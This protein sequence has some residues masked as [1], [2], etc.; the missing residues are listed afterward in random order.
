MWQRLQAYPLQLA[1][2]ALHVFVV[3]Q[4]KPNYPIEMLETWLSAAE[5]ERA[6]AYLTKVL[7][8]RY[9][10]RHGMLREILSVY[11][12]CKPAQLEFVTGLNG[13]PRLIAK[14]IHF[15][16]SHS[17]EYVLIGVCKTPIGIDI[18][19][20][21]DVNDLPLIAEYHFAQE[22]QDALFALPQREQLDGFYR[23]WTRKEAFIKMDG[24]GL[25]IALDS[26]IVSIG[27]YAEVIKSNDVDV[28]TWQIKNVPVPY[29]YAGAVVMGRHIKNLAIIST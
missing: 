25:G 29:N 10:T 28:D 24:R 9:V 6:K 14:G 19:H 20:K 26:F 17:D 2:D 18:E 23:C 5:K 13:K 12:A 15:N 27:D 3:N 8:H 1:E 11:L 21:N 4:D 16:L 7:Q 22:E